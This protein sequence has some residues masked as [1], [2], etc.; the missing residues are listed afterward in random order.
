MTFMCVKNT[1]LVYGENLSCEIHIR[2]HVIFYIELVVQNLIRRR[3]HVHRIIAITHQGRCI[4]EGLYPILRLLSWN[5]IRV[6]GGGGGLIPV[7]AHSSGLST[8]WRTKQA[9]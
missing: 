9:G 5:S 8:C 6:W 1:E 3:V 2:E 4:R 7:R